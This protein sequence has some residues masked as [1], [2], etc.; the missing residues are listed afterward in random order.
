MGVHAEA[1]IRGLIGYKLG[2]PSRDAIR[3]TDADDLRQEAVVQLL[4]EIQR[5]R[6]QP[7][8]H[9]IT[10]VRGLAAVI[11]HRACPRRMR[12]QFPERHA[13]KNRLHYLLTRQNN[14]AVWRDENNKLIAGFAVWRPHKMQAIEE[15]VELSDDETFIAQV[16]L[17]KSGRQHAESATTLGAI[18]N[19]L[20]RPIELD[21]LVSAL[22]ALWSIEERPTR[23]RRGRSTGVPNLGKISV[24][25][26]SLGYSLSGFPPCDI[27][28]KRV[29][30]VVTRQGIGNFSL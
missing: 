5:F 27:P 12:G 3:Q 29:W 10:D 14:F 9:P 20:H 16:R 26:Q 25:S 18:F 4:A 24:P 19:R 6:E 8:M 21:K 15:R 13:M 11:A 28:I 30:P 17:L 23:V 2:L 22:V 7:K 1:V